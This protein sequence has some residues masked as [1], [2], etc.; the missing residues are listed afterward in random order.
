MDYDE[1]TGSYYNAPNVDVIVPGVGNVTLVEYV[2]TYEERPLKVIP[3]FDKFTEYF[4]T[5][6]SYVRGKDLR[7]APYDWRLAPSTY[8]H[9]VILFIDSCSVHNIYSL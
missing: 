2:N 8:I 9:F 3:N 1:A 5:N 4:V 6:Y 7:G